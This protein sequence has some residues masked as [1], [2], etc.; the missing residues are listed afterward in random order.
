M[1]LSVTGHRPEKL[2]RQ[3]P[4]SKEQFKHLI[5]FAKSQLLK[6][7]PQKVL[8]GM[9]LGWDQAVALACINLNIPYV[10][11]V[12][13]YN[14]DRKWSEAY[15]KLYAELLEKS[16]SVKYVHEGGYTQKCMLDRN[17]YMVENSDKVLTLWNGDQMGGT[18]HCVRYAT[19][20]NKEIMNAWIQWLEYKE[21]NGIV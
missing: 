3:N 15:Q 10:A 20:M 11:C 5:R 4:Y 21:S 1:I 7:K 8:T 18:A 13:C 12:P 17:I 16:E 14:Q 6:V 9:A 19:K 2:L